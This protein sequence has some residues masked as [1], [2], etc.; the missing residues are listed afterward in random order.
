MTNEELGKR[1]DA[2]LAVKHVV[3]LVDLGFGKMFKPEVAKLAGDYVDGKHKMMIAE[4][5]IAD[6]LIH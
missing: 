3:A 4:C 5:Q 2:R 6:C 1:R